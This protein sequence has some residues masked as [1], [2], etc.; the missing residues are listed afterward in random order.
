MVSEKMVFS[1]LKSAMGEEYRHGVKKEGKGG[2]PREL[3]Y[4]FRFCKAKENPEEMKGTLMLVIF[5]EHGQHFVAVFITF[6]SE[7]P[8]RKL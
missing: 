3:L 4:S 8:K 5:F 6:R 2:G 1:V 7:K